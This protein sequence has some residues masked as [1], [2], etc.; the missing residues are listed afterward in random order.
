MYPGGLF[1]PTSYASVPWAS[2][3]CGLSISGAGGSEVIYVSCVCMC[4]CVYECYWRVGSYLIA[5]RIQR[6]DR[7]VKKGKQ[8]FIK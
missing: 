2:L 7:E 6:Q 3:C 8:A 4:V 1:S 5:E